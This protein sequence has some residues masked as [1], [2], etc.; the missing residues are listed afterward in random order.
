MSIPQ[1]QIMQTKFTERINTSKALNILNMPRR[2]VKETFWDSDETFQDGK[3][4]Q[5]STYFNTLNKYLQSA[6]KGGGVLVREYRYA[7]NQSSGRMY[8][9]HC[10][11]QT[12]QNRIRNYV[13]GE[14]YYDFDICSCHPSILLHICNKFNLSAPSL[15][16]YVE[17]RENMLSEHNLD[18]KDILV[19]MNRDVNSD[20]RGNRYYN[21]LV[22][23]LDYVK[24]IIV[25][26]LK[27]MGITTTNTKNPSSSLLNKYIL[28]YEDNIIQT[29]VKFFGEH[30]EVLMFD[31]IMVSKTFCS[32]EDLPQHVTS[33]N[34]LFVEEYHGL[35]KFKVKSTD[36]DVVLKDVTNGVEEYDVVK[37]RFE[38]D[39]FQTVKPFAYWKRNIEADGSYSSNQIRES[40]FRNA[41][42]E[43]QI[44]DYNHRGELVPT[45]IFKKWVDDT[46][47]RKYE[48]I[49]FV[50]YGNEDT[51]P[52]HVYNTFEGFE[53]NKI[54]EY[55]KVCTGNFDELIL[56]LC[57]EDKG[58]AEY[59][60]KYIAH[61]F[62]YPNELTEKIIVLKGWTGTGKDTLFR[63][64]QRLMGMKYVDITESPE[65][66]FGNFNSIMD[67][68]L[69]LFM[70][71]LEGSDGIK[72]QEKLKAA[73]SNLKNT[74][75]EKYQKPVH[76]NNYCR[77][78]V[79]SNNDG[80]VN[81]KS[82]DRRYIVIKTG[83]KLVSKVNDEEQSRKAKKFWTNYYG[84]LKD[85]NWR[86][87]L[88]LRLMSMD[89]SNYKP[90]NDPSTEEKQLMQEKN[91]QPVHAFLKQLLTE[92]KYE[93]FATKTIKGNEFHLIKWSNFTSLFHDW[94]ASN[95][96]LEYKIKDTAIKQ[97]VSNMGNSFQAD[98]S[99][100]HEVN[101]QKKKEKFACFDMKKMKLFLDSFIF[102]DEKE[103]A[104]VDVGK[105]D[106]KAMPVRERGFPTNLD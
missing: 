34:K 91:L 33:L 6:V 95:C 5:W 30:A 42:C 39:H 94:T 4:W 51:C 29:A 22:Y 86:K 14:F 58:M 99:I 38:L 17:N 85:A 43:Y 65:S 84:S 27:D 26:K 73:A 62:Q 16:R 80:C 11:I 100:T 67:S 3:Q 37:E 75:N 90:S 97:K 1:S 77:L 102:N 76:Q 59:L 74:V 32:E 41:C 10:G 15:K 96:Q 45:S 57:N 104:T 92:K 36:S 9:E 69:C 81:I 98:K 55:E 48:C 88:Y 93:G 8:V 63:T 105:L 68:K 28:Q 18:K 70:N 40:D 7:K 12:L 47:K 101:G 53:V 24:E 54:T 13:C 66:L 103:E 72:Y 21:S 2:E 87:S 71:E 79:N 64:I 82:D 23:E 89:L 50:P 20:K 61:M 83:L 49:D 56:N 44:I 78:F 60:L 106:I 31:G 46:E 25:P 52:S 35:I 19:A